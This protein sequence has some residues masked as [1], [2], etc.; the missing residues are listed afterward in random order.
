MESPS[1]R[2]SARTVASVRYEVVA[3]VTNKAG[4][5]AVRGFGQAPTISSRADDGSRRARWESTGS[6][7]GGATSSSRR[8]SVHDP[9]RNA[10]RQRQLSDGAGQGGAAADIDALI[11][12]RDDARAHGRVAGSAS[13]RASN[14]AAATRS[15]RRC[16]PERRLDD[17]PRRL[18][19][20]DRPARDGQRAD[21]R[22]V[23]GQRPRDAVSAVL[24]E[25]FGIDPD[26][27]G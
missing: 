22:G 5:V 6:R 23:V 16:S 11:R 18:S 2:S 8:L 7:C 10:V 17:V 20:Q 12:W 15:F 1:G 19:G 25:E 3:V 26:Q 4:Q 9:E 24:G 27:I 14:P 21:R 13:R